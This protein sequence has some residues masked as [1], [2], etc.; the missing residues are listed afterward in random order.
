MAS[1]STMT[2]SSAASRQQAMPAS[3]QERLRRCFDNHVYALGQMR[4]ALKLVWSVACNTISLQ[5]AQHHPRCNI[6]LGEPQ[7]TLQPVV[8]EE[9][10]K[11]GCHS[12]A[13][14]AGFCSHSRQWHPSKAAEGG[15][16]EQPAADSS[17]SQCSASRLT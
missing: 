6:I 13:L 17:F 8:I 11:E 14:R 4:S 5:D 12:G 15:Q 2:A 3:L 7:D 10:G 1:T 16:G 9:V